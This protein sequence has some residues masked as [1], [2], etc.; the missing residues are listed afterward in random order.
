MTSKLMPTLEIRM[1]HQVLSLVVIMSSA[2]GHLGHFVVGLMM[3]H[4]VCYFRDC[5]KFCAE[6]ALLA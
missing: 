2:T 6:Q 3:L 1:L 5:K 4:V